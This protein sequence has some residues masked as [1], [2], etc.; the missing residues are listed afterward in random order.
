LREKHASGADRGLLF[1]DGF[2]S[3]RQRSSG[4]LEQ[5]SPEDSLRGRLSY[6]GG[7]R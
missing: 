2:V 1:R 3:L 6:E 5:C 7:A 4:D